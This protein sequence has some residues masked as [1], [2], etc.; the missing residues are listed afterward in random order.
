MIFFAEIPFVTPVIILLLACCM[1]WLLLKIWRDFFVM[2]LRKLR[3]FF[4]TK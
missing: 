1:L 3:S 2:V 4:S